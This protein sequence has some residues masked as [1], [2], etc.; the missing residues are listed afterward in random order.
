MQPVEMASQEHFSCAVFRYAKKYSVL[1]SSI[2]NKHLRVL[3][4][5]IF[6]KATLL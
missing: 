4:F 5:Q 3:I 1:L 6:A 2:T